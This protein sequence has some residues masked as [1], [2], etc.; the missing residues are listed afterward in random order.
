MDMH[1]FSRWTRKLVF[2]SLAVNLIFF[3]LFGYIVFKKGG[4]GYLVKR[5]QSILQSD[6]S[7]A[8]SSDSGKRKL[9][10]PAHYF[11]RKS[12]YES[13]ADEEN[14]IIFLGDSI[15]DDGEWSELFKDLKIKN[16]GIQGDRT[17]GILKRLQEVVSSSPQKIFLLIGY[18]DLSKGVKIDAIVLNY[19][20]ILQTIKTRSPGTQIY[21]QSVLPVNYNSYKGRV[22][23]RDVIDLNRQLKQLSKKF[24]AHYLDLYS[25]F[26][27]ADQQLHPD[28]AG[29]DGLHLNGK[30]YLKWKSILENHVY[31]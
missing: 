15:T 8:A 31:N 11:D 14:E 7:S 23:N 27:D 5:T 29:K 16:R 12:I 18:N 19:E 1:N 3:F 21:I 17:D 6:K 22:K 10:Y 9:S 20:K 26:S 30:A 13:L 4:I 2:L 24:N 28:F 25:N